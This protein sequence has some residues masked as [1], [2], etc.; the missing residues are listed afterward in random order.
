MR[1]TVS[2]STCPGW[3]VTQKGIPVKELQPAKQSSKVRCGGT[4]TQSRWKMLEGAIERRTKNKTPSACGSC[5]DSWGMWLLAPKWSAC[6][7]PPW[8]RLTLRG[9]LARRRGL[10]R[11]LIANLHGPVFSGFF[12]GLEGG[13]EETYHFAGSPKKKEG[14]PRK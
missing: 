5:W 4:P 11:E 8:P 2:P 14:T 12:V 10:A 6:N 13:Q 7:C 1:K 9:Q 3:R